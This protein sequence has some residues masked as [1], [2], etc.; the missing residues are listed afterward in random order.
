M[1]AEILSSI[2]VS[3][4]VSLTATLIVLVLALILAPIFASSESRI[5][6]CLELFFYVP[7]ALPPVALGFLLLDFF[8]PQSRMGAFLL[9]MGVE[10]AFSFWGA[11][12]ASIFASFGIALRTIKNALQALDPHYRSMAQL[13]G[14]HR[15]EAYFYIEIPLIGS[16][17]FGSALIVFIRSLGEFG[18]TM[19][20]AGNSPGKTRTLALAIWTDMQMPDSQSALILVIISCLLSLLALLCCEFILSRAHKF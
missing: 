9:G 14:A 7:M 4:R 20:F 8:G 11:V 18:A 15:S 5:I 10:L 12:L 6:K 3:L 17:I 16:S 13:M 2:F 19:I 1:T